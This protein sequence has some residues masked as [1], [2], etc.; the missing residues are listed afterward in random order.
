[1]RTTNILALIGAV[2]AVVGV[3]YPKHLFYRK[4]VPWEYLNNGMFIVY[5]DWFWGKNDMNLKEFIRMN[6]TVTI[7]NAFPA[8]TNMYG[9]PGAMILLTDK[10][11]EKRKKVVSQAS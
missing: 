3:F 9:A 5:P 8:Y 4:T 1:M 6:P 7:R 10:E 11:N 2:A